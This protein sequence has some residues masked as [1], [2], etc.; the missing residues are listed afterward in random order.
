M[1]RSTAT[2]VKI[3]VVLDAGGEQPPAAPPEPARQA[4]PP[5]PARPAAADE[6]RQNIRATS[7]V[8]EPA[9]DEEV[10]SRDDA[11]VEEESANHDELLAKHLG[12][13]LIGEEEPPPAP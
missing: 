2:Q 6:A 12:A 8:A 13:E 11:S 9:P 10:P 5:R 7:R 4:P 1:Q 3:E